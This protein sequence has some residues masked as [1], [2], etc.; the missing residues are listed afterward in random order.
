M[1]FILTKWYFYRSSYLIRIAPT[2]CYEITPT[3]GR[4]TALLLCLP[5]MSSPEQTAGESDAI[6]NTMLDTA[7]DQ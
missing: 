5:S 6:R 3:K 4:T 7:A 1:S 2:E